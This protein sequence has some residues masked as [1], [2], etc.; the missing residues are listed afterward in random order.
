MILSAENRRLLQRNFDLY[1]RYIF[2]AKT[3]REF[4]WN[5]HHAIISNALMRSF[6]GLSPRLIINI[7]PR[8]SKTLLAVECFA[9]W[10]FGHY[11]D[12]EFLHS[13]YSSTLAAK[14]SYAIRALLQHEAYQAV[15]DNVQLQD[16]SKARHWWKTADG[17]TFY[18]T[19]AEGTIT[20][21]GAGK[22]ETGDGFGGAF[23]I[24]DPHK[25]LEA[26]RSAVSRQ[27]VIDWFQGTVETRLNSQS[28]P[29]ILI[30][31]RLHEDDLSG[32]LLGGGNGENWEHVSLPVIQPDGTALWVDKHTLT[33]LL[34]M[35]ST[36][37]YDFAGQ[38]MQNPVPIGGGMVKNDWFLER[39]KLLPHRVIRIVQSWDTGQKDKKERNDPS[40]CTTWAECADGYYLLDVFREWLEYPALERAVIDQHAKHGA[41]V[42]LVEDKSSGQTLIQRGRTGQIGK[43]PIIPVMPRTDKIDRLESVTGLMQSG[44]VKLPDAAPWI[45]DY[46]SELTTFPLSAHDDQAD[47]TSQ[48]L[49]WMRDNSGRH[50]AIAGVRSY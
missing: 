3:G 9:S 40:V 34:L 29:I 5:K 49:A 50:Y 38:Y 15:F 47:S 8:Y 27:A 7:P 37:P 19:G 48:A 11:P 17:G 43:I 6:C 25:A 44:R 23:L 14:N 46:L 20:G 16:D 39:Y 22:V 41:H 1:A 10:A 33:D 13:S 4:R 26:K 42:V 31:Q 30:M 2:T 24:D 35:Q 18:A 36:K 45:A 12:A 32:W 21:F 28:T